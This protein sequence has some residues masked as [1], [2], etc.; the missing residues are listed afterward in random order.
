MIED[1]I[2][3]TVDIVDSWEAAGFT[4]Q[5][6]RYYR[7]NGIGIQTVLRIRSMRNESTTD[8]TLTVVGAKLGPSW[9]TV[10]NLIGQVINDTGKL[11]RIS[12]RDN[13]V[14]YRATGV[15][16]LTFLS[17]EGVFYRVEL[18]VL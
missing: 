6:S 11:T 14:D 3:E 9:E 1:P 8:L 12:R 17:S 18:T 4:P 13:G 15:Y 2:K 10:E 5:E 16:D 7:R